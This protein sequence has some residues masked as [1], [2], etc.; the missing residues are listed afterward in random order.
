MNCVTHADVNAVATILFRRK[1]MK[2]TKEVLFVLSV[3]CMGLMLLGC[4]SGGSSLN[5]ESTLTIQNSPAGY[6]FFA[7]VYPSSSRPY[8][9]S[10]YNSMT[11]TGIAV[12]RGDD[13][14]I[15]LIWP[16]EKQSGNFLVVV[17]SG[18]TEKFDIVNFDRKGD[19]TVNWNVM[20]DV[21]VLP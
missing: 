1:A 8:T 21:T 3:L 16:K 11:T 7:S 15:S 9:R 2:K 12:G 13:S 20:T 18:S 6:S 10:D 19:A 14:S 5:Y 4:S 17:R